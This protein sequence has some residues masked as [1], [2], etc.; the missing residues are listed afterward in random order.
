LG[1]APLTK[2]TIVSPRSDYGEVVRKLSVFAEFH[3]IEGAEP[4]FDPFVQGLAVRAVSLYARTDETIRD[5]SIQPGPGTLD[6]VFRGAKVPKE[7][8]DAKDWDDLITKA[9][10]ILNPVAE[11]VKTRKAELQ[12]VSKE[13]NDSKTLRD[14]LRLVSGLSVDLG[15]ANRLE[16]VKV[17]LTIV[18]SSVLPEFRNSL[19]GV[20]FQSQALAEDENLVL[21]ASQ[22]SEFPRVSKAMKALELKPLVLPQDLPQNPVDAY[23]MLNERYETAKKS[24]VEIEADIGRLR[25]ENQTNL[26]AIK[27]LAEL[28]RNVLDVTRM[29]GRM[30]RIATISGYVPSRRLSEFQS[31][32]G[33]WMVY[34]EPVEPH[35]ESG[36]NVPTLMENRGPLRHFEIITKE[37]G[38]PGTHEVDPTPL[39]SFVFPIFFGIMFGDLGHG[40][41]LTLFAV[42]LRHRGTGSLRQWGN[43]FLAAGISACVVGVIVGEF[44]GFSLY[45]TLHIPG[46]AILE[47]VSRSTGQ[48][49]LSQSGLNLALE[50]AILIGVAHL[51]TA[52]SL[53]V[54]EAIKGHERIEL[55]TEKLPALSMYIFGVGFG[56]AFIGANYSFQVLS[57]PGK[58]PLL[59]VP[60]SLV[61]AISTVGVLGSM[62][63]LLTGKG[64]AVMTGR[65]HGGSAGGAFGNGAIEVFERISGYM[66]N[67][68]SYVRLAIMLMIHAEL[69][70]V[71]NMLLN[72]PLYAAAPMVIIF[73]I[74][75]IVF[76][77]LIVYIQDLR[78]HI[79]EFFT[80]FYKGTGTPF[81]RILPEGVRIKI[82][83]H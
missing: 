67:T 28:A 4:A 39:I 27:E 23:R 76:E 5:L 82:R 14:A 24:R 58:T 32:F 62:L 64:I 72:L 69:L 43:I 48:A 33:A 9:E 63:V 42:L 68:I 80:K 19:P 15:T 2:V 26:L 18:S 38:T 6:V 65:A 36:P 59:G 75:I 74:L 66:A 31:S 21:I 40:I 16:R 56:L 70:L 25:G 46:S 8:I 3:P 20:V 51:T 10:G 83:W 37:Q 57:S 7:E 73:N 45:E 12:N 17:M 1:S 81:R 77:V 13:E 30:K 54:I 52:L 50:I 41:I 49:T 60:N 22:P 71:V 78:L 53:D 44:F 29:A 34:V 55:V 79:Y 61:G 35:N 47:I 11:K